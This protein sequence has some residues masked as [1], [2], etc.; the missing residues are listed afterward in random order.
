MEGEGGKSEMLKAEG[1]KAEHAILYPQS[2]ILSLRKA[3]VPHYSFAIQTE[4]QFGRFPVFKFVLQVG[5]NGV[6]STSPE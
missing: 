3:N 1:L 4:F 5:S 2:S 6:F